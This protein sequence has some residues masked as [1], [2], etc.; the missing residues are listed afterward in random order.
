MRIRVETDL[1]IQHEISLFIYFL[2]IP[3]KRVYVFPL[4]LA[5]AAMEYLPRI[6]FEFFP[7]AR[8]YFLISWTGSI[9]DLFVRTSKND[10]FRPIRDFAP[11]LQR[12]LFRAFLLLLFTI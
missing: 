11:D 5:L 12:A 10:I 4:D 2:Q 1:Y 6:L 9:L 8:E 3:K 7:F